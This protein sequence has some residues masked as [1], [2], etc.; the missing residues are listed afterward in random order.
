MLPRRK[1]LITQ[2]ISAYKPGAFIT[3]TLYRLLQLYLRQVL[4]NI[5]YI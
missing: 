4:N 1:D 2:L 3:D 5:I